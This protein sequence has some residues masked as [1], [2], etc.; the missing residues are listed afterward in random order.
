[1]VDQ[2]EAVGL[3]GE[4]CQRFLP[5]QISDTRQAGFEPGQNLSSVIV[6]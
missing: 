2:R 4:T 6:E 3:P 1:M 5:S